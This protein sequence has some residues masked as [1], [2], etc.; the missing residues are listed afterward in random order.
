MRNTRRITLCG[1]ITA[2]ACALMYIG[3]ATDI[4]SLTASVISAFAVLFVYIE[5]GLGTG[6][7]V[8][9]ATSIISLLI[10]PEKFAA[11]L[12]LVYVGYYPILKIRIEK[13]K[14]R[15]L[16]WAIKLISFN[17]VLAASLAISK[18]ILLVEYDA[19]YIEAATIIVANAAFVLADILATRMIYLYIRKYRQ[20]LK[21]SGFVK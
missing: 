10:C 9:A 16:V 4:F 15:V 13:I 21:K 17:I 6:L 3:A 19:F 8:Y 18:Y 1:V 5:Y 12:F 20:I 7:M 11:L 14:N 2:L